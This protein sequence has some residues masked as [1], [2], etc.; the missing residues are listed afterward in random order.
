[1]KLQHGSANRARII[2]PVKALDPV[3]H[4]INQ[5]DAGSGSTWKQG[6]LLLRIAEL[7]TQID[8]VV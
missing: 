3:R 5:L 4:Q 2:L 6:A 1:M 8:R 7:E